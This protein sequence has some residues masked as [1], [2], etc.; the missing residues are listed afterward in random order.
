MSV[1]DGTALPVQF[2]PVNQA[3]PPADDQRM[4]AANATRQTNIV[5]S[6]VTIT[7]ATRK[8]RARFK[9]FRLVDQRD[10]PGDT[11]SPAERRCDSREPA[12]RVEDD[13]EAIREL[14]MRRCD[15]FS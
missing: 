14:M 1:F 7:K 3:E 11:E 12:D 10:V 4:V 6:N 5:V 13:L 2:V 8:V 15:M 9:C